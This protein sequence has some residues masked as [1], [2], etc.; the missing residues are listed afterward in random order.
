MFTGLVEEV[1]SIARTV[2]TATGARIAIACRLGRGEPLVLGESIAVMGVCLTVDRLDDAGFEADAS[3]ETLAR[4]TL[5]GLAPGAAVNLERASKLGARMGGHVVLGHVDGVASVRAVSAA[6]E[7]RR[8]ELELARELAPFVAAKGSIT[9]DGVSLTLNEVADLA[10]G[11]RAALMLV[12]HTLGRTTLEQIAPG[13]TV[14][15]EVD[16]LARYVARQLALAASPTRAAPDE[17]TLLEKLK[18]GGYM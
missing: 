1:G 4:T 10:G 6:G 16:V 15:V 3:R 17:S 11:V 18:S 2:R 12:P 9:V 14:N 8:V 5:G 7:A 13:Q